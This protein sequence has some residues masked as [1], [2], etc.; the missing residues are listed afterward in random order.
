GI[1]DASAPKIRCVGRSPMAAIIPAILHAGV[2]LRLLGRDAAPRTPRRD[3]R[4]GGD[5]QLHA[6]WA[7]GA[8]AFEKE[9]AA[10]CP[11]SRPATRTHATMKAARIAEATK[12]SSASPP[13]ATGLSNRSPSVA[14]SGRVRMKALQ[15]SRVRETEVK[16][17]AV[18]TS[19]RPVPFGFGWIWV[20]SGGLARRSVLCLRRKGESVR[21]LARR[22]EP[23]DRAIFAG[24]D[25]SQ[26]PER[27]QT[28]QIRNLGVGERGCRLS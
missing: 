6:P 25:R 27:P 8:Y 14:P 19:S 9:P 20:R 18:A 4:R 17:Y 1:A 21:L 3:R 12:R 10:D 24:R 5:A 23:L 13:C 2:E 22:E 28:F 16:R 15:K 26:V 7:A 11:E